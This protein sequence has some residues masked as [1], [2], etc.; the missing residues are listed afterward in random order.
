MGIIDGY[1]KTHQRIFP[2]E[3]WR[4]SELN[5]ESEDTQVS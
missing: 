1:G 4:N 5:F 3:A 2:C